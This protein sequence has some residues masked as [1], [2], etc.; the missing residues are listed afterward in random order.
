[1][2]VGR[3]T[4]S[5]SGTSF[6]SA[7]SRSHSGFGAVSENALPSRVSAGEFRLFDIS[8]TLTKIASQ[9][10]LSQDLLARALE[11]LFARG[12]LATASGAWCTP[13]SPATAVPVCGL[14][15]GRFAFGLPALRLFTEDMAF[16]PEVHHPILC[17]L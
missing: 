2:S 7:T 8:G 17:P 12:R 5:S 11:P 4:S 1:M 13:R 6:A 14:S 16:S 10:T 3:P 9:T 15:V